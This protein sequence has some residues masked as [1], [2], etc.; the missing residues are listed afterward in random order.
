MSHQLGHTSFSC[1]ALMDE[2][3]PV[4]MHDGDVHGTVAQPLGAHLAT[5]DRAQHDVVTIDDVDHLCRGGTTARL[6]ISIRP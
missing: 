4:G 5:G 1:A 6:V 3:P 2:Q